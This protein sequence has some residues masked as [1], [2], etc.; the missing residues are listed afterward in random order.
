MTTEARLG[1][2]FERSATPRLGQAE[3]GA[4]RPDRLTIWPTEDGYGIDVRWHGRECILRAVVVR[5][6]LA[7]AGIDARPGN[8]QDGRLWELRVGPVPADEVA[9]V[10]E[11][12]I[13]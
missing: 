10:I 2:R 12:Y 9:R 4:I 3:P 1:P 5:R 6:L 13:W 11:A 7:E 8:S